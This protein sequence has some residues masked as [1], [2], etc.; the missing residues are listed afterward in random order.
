MLPDGMWLTGASDGIIRFEPGKLVANPV[1]PEVYLQ[2]LTY[3]K[4][5]NRKST[6]VCYFIK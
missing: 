4:Q 5:G 6:D 1:P 3:T 2:T